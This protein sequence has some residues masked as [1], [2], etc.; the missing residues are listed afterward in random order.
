[1]S[2]EDLF[3]RAAGAWTGPSQLWLEPGSDPRDCVSEAEVVRV[4]G[5]RFLRLSYTWS[6]EGA[7][8]SGELLIAR[9]T[10]EGRWTAVWG[11]SWHQHRSLLECR[12]PIEDPNAF[13]ARGE[14][15][16]GEGHPNWGWSIGLTM[17]G[18]TLVLRMWNE[19]PEHEP[20]LAVETR[21]TRR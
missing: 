12:G 20:V 5:E 9:D 6:Y 2:G 18:E 21:Y 11:D 4:A 3:A 8:K 19:M 7:A 10:D 1:M 14:Y 13:R 15:E 16:V 17:E